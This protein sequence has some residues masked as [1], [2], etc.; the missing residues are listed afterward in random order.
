MP[1]QRITKEMVVT[2]A[3]ELA[4]EGGMEQVLVK[5]IAAKIGCSVQP[6]Y[7]YCNNM[8]ELKEEVIARIRVHLHAYVKQHL[9]KNFQFQ[10]AGLAHAKFAKEEPQLYRAYFL[11]KREPMHS[12]AE[13]FQSEASPDVA[14]RISQEYGITEAQARELHLNMMI[15][16][17]GISFILSTLGEHT[18]ISEIE[19]LLDKACAA[20]RA[21]LS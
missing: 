12:V 1:K 15:Y 5:N 16:N 11:R 7:C 4:R 21:Q 9:G 6:I 3:F 20:F 18:D 17:V 10:D 13:I 19:Q 2:A 8:D 14:V